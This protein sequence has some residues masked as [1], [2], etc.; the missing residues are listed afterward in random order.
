MK[1]KILLV[2]L[3]STFS[4]AQMN[5]EACL[6]LQLS[7]IDYV[8]ASEKAFNDKD[9]ISFVKNIEKEKEIITKFN[10]EKCY[11]YFP[12]SEKIKENGER[13]ILTLEQVLK[14]GI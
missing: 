1:S 10:N 5:K 4:F 3:L 6:S 12:D 8:K 13:V 7:I 2:V 9:K 11:N 14:K